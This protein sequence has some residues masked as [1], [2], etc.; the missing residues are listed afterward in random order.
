MIIIVQRG[1]RVGRVVGEGPG[2]EGSLVE[3]SMSYGISA[4]G[5]LCLGCQD[6]KEPPLE[7]L[8]TVFSQ[9]Y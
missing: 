4:A 9:N 6:P 1:E 2:E 5:F 8:G 7:S 3:D